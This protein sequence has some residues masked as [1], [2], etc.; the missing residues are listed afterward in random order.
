MPERRY[1]TA[2]RIERR[3]PGEGEVEEPAMPKIVGRAAS[4]NVWTT[5]YESKYSVVRERINKGAFANALKEKQD[6]RGLFNHDPN[7]VL[8]RTASG[9]L[10]LTDTEEGLEYEIEPPETDTVRDLVLVPMERGDI[11]GSSFAFSVRDGGEKWTEY[12][13]GGRD[14]YEREVTDADLYDVSPVT[15]PAYEASTSGLRSAALPHELRGRIE[16]RE[17]TRSKAPAPLRESFRRWLDG[18]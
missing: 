7:F 6:V 4:Y 10:T 18:A 13:E 9:T 1:S 14:V 16:A 8:G 2:T 12:E 15:Y 17:K 11:T 3:S 5:L